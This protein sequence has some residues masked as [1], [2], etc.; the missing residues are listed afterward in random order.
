MVHT[1]KNRRIGWIVGILAVT[2]LAVVKIM[3]PAQAG[4][5]SAWSIAATEGTVKIHS[6]SDGAIL[7]ELGAVIPPG[8]RIATGEDG[9]VELVRGGDSM[10]V[11][12]NTHMTIPAERNR[13]AA[14]IVESLGSILFRME[15][16]ESRDFQVRTPYLAAAVK[17]TVFTVTADGLGARVL[18]EEGSVLVTAN[19]SGQSAMI[20]AGHGG[21]VAYGSDSVIL[22]GGVDTGSSSSLGDRD[23]RGGAAKS[24]GGMDD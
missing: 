24:G 15:S 10:T 12:P 18:V 6:S 2:V 13:G 3:A 4:D 8:T 21:S 19:R 20:Y 16:R 9:Q 14:S 17:G 1:R 5:V 7:P 22:D 23:T 11:M